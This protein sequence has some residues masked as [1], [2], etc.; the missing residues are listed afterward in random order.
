MEIFTVE[1]FKCPNCKHEVSARLS[2]SNFNKNYFDEGNMGARYEYEVDSFPIQC[3]SCSH[4]FTISGSF[5][6]YPEGAFETSDLK[7]D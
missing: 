7:L 4:S 3:E 1:S 6:E 2:S 5:W